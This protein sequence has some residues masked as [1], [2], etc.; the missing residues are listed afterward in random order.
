MWAKF[1]TLAEFD[2]WHTGI[3]NQLG[4]PRPDG[5]T[6]EYTEAH[7]ME[8]NTY[9]AWVDI[10]YSDGLSEGLVWTRKKGFN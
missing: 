3:K 5:I 4:I 7:L 2:A 8:D 10:E 6:T 1:N 9:S